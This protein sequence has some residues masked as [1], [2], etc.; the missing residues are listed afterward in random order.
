MGVEVFVVR[1]DCGGDGTTGL[2]VCGGGSQ[3]AQSDRF[4]ASSELSDGLTL[5]EKVGYIYI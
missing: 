3:S 2:S 4:G 1:H 5:S